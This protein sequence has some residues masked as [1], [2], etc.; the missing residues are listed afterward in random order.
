ML[1]EEEQQKIKRQADNVPC[2]LSFGQEQLWLIHELNPQSAAYNMPKLI[3]LKGQLDL[4][5]LEKTLNSILARHE[6]LR[7]N[8][9]LTDGVPKAFV[10]DASSVNLQ[11]VDL[12]VIASDEREKK[13]YEYIYSE[14]N[15]PFDLEE[16]L[17]LR[18]CLY[19]LDV[20]DHMLL[21][22]V[23]HIACDGKSGGLWMNEIVA[24]YSAFINANEVCLPELPIQYSDY[25]RWQ[26]EQVSLPEMAAQ[27]KY[28]IKNLKGIPEKLKLPENRPRPKVKNFHGA[29][30][31]R[32]YPFEKIEAFSKLARKECVT[33]FL[34]LFS[35]FNALIFRYTQENDIVI[36][37]PVST[38]SKIETENLIGF[39]INMI[40]I[41]IQTT[42]RCSFRQILSIVKEQ[43]LDAHMNSG[44]PF[45]KLVKH[46][47]P[48][49]KV[50]QNP[51]FQIIF[52]HFLEE[53]TL[54]QS[55][56]LRFE[57]VSLNRNRTPVDQYWNVGIIE[58]KVH[59]LVEYDT[60]LFNSNTIDRMANHYLKLLDSVL[61]TPDIPIADISIVETHEMNRLLFQSNETF[62]EYP[63][64]KCIH[65]LFEVQVEKTLDATAVVF[66]EEALT[67]QQ[68][69]E[70]ANQLAH[71]LIRLG[72]GPETL[73]GLCLDRSLDLI[74]GILGILKAGG[75][76]VPLDISHPSQRL[77][78]ILEDAQVN[79]L[80]TH[81][82]L[83]EQ[84]PAS[85]EHTILLTAEN[86]AIA[87][88]SKENLPCRTKP[89]QLAY[90]MYTSGSTGQPK[91]VQIPHA[92]V[93]NF[94]ISMAVEPGLTAKDRLLSVTTPTFDISVLELLLPLT[95]GA[96]VDIASSEITSD[97][98]G[99][100]NRLT[101]TGATVMQATPATWQM[102]IQAGWEGASNLKVL[103]G[104][105]ALSDKLATELL[106]RCGELWNMYGPTETTIWSTCLRVQDGGTH[107]SI[108][109]PIANTQTY[110]L[111]K[112]RQLVPVGVPGELYISGA[113]LARGYLNR[114]D[115][116]A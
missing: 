99:L 105:E 53:K 43:T 61:S 107:G 82:E 29:S 114:P 33:P 15:D 34:F 19:K 31:S 113:G 24:H 112:N 4:N 115:L 98:A 18:C 7:T 91:G 28:W 97:A 62:S 93:V 77:E 84:L 87:N 26:R 13:L 83:R 75:A 85:V 60:D 86:E 65:E 14:V 51:I 20:R 103:C 66:K 69:N 95:V 72:V 71:H 52:N 8:Y 36:G 41:R 21:I 116:T 32:S 55:G 70:R 59:I 64:N 46:L 10:R 44:V 56:G 23:H 47:N 25:A 38:R 89:D 76:Y 90:T 68:L 88:S 94:L 9:L 74:V 67:Y 108:G 16:D 2:E 48:G 102:L 104:G 81:P 37:C 57:R 92:A 3:S 27:L 110:L 79:Y 30:Y 45:E 6:I 17:M 96:S 1:K 101:Q 58:K 11:M 5:A 80:L 22:T 35:V 78:F 39:F 109:R 42:D 73:V 54:V 49:R 63:R 40:A 50:N 12:S 100:A 106:P 111:D